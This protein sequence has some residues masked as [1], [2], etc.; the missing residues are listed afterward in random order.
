MQLT[1]VFRGFCE[2]A[3]HAMLIA[4]TD[5]DIIWSNAAAVRILG[6]ESPAELSGKPVINSLL[7]PGIA[8]W[9]DLL[10]RFRKTG[11][12]TY[13][14]VPSARMNA[15]KLD[16]MVSRVSVD[17][18]ERYYIYLTPVSVTVDAPLSTRHDEERLNLALQCA[19][20]GVWD[21]NLSSGEMI[22]DGRWTKMAG[23]RAEELMPLTAERFIEFVHPD[24]RDACV[25]L[26]SGW[27]EGKILSGS[28]KMR[29]RH[30]NGTWVWIR[31]QW[32]VFRSS[33]DDP[34]LRVFGIH[35]DITDLVRKDEAIREAQKKIATLSS[36]TRHDIL[37]HVTVI[38]ML[39]DIMEMTGEVP[40][41]SDTWVQLSKIN[42][43][44]LAIERRI[45]FTR[46]YED[47]G[48]E[49]PAW[50]DIG[51]LVARMADMSEFS[52]LAVS[53]TCNNLKVYAD[54]MLERVMH[55]LFTN[56]VSHG[57]DVTTITVSCRTGADS[58]TVID[59]S[60]DGAGIA[61]DRKEKI[62]SRGVGINTRYGL[63]LSREILSVTGIAIQETG[64]EE[65]GAVF[66]LSVPQQ[67]WKMSPERDISS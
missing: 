55:E 63:Y 46:D 52:H 15:D 64:T 57:G 21:I 31:S 36:V 40:V 49:P 13:S 65:N 9:D 62:F 45:V 26:F 29:M 25:S 18:K 12:F 27:C 17:G 23:Y 58:T 24:D 2:N 30:K 5:G 54:P 14:A 16:V 4:D 3:P 42:D 35:Q 20:L 22:V 19:D 32:Q 37:N 1:D 39:F 41:D 11:T 7:S 34:V 56:A 43:E 47:L 59:V 66:S 38:R 10:A 67:N 48:S 60:D 50:Q 53:C 33:E 44:A 8:K 51:Y 6:K 61:A 28:H